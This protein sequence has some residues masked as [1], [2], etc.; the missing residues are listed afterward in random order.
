MLHL[1]G[2]PLHDQAPPASPCGDTQPFPSPRL[3]VMRGVEGIEELRSF[4][5]KIPDFFGYPK[6]HLIVFFEALNA[7]LRVIERC[8][9]LKSQ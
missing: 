7:L 4:W 3:W 5:F 9:C 1:A 8:H 2:Q 6:G